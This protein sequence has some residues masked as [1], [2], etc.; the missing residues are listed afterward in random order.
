MGRESPYLLP[1]PLLG[2]LIGL[3]S[4]TVFTVGVV[5]GIAWDRLSDTLDPKVV[6][7]E[8][9][10]SL[11]QLGF[12][13]VPTGFL[14]GLIFGLT[15]RTDSKRSE[16]G[17]EAQEMSTAPTTTLMT[18]EDY[19]E[20]GQRAENSRKRT[21]LVRGEVVEMSSPGEIH[22]SVCWLISFLFGLYVVK[23][24]RGR[25]TANDTGLVVEEG[26]DTV[27]GPDLMFFDESRALGTLNWKHARQIPQLVIEVVS[28]TDTTNKI[29]RRIGEYLRRG[30][31]LV[32]IV[33]PADRT[34][35]VH[36]RGEL[37]KTLDETDELTGDDV[38]PDLKWRV[39]E[40]FTLPA[41]A[42]T[43]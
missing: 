32:W 9:L 15:A 12:Y 33:D 38:L 22:G 20:W 40:L 7:A 10:I 41:S 17:G 14:V 19:W 23:R 6:M 27:R 37:P 29:N 35:G 24:G 34:V 4:G 36:R 5:A 1:P 30:V 31:P 16:R 8:G 13:A 18:A 26:P 42:P 25:A 3:A 2:S 39:A 43:A 21:E 28:P 11:V